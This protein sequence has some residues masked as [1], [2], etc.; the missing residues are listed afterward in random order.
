MFGIKNK[1]KELEKKLDEICDDALEHIRKCSKEPFK[2]EAVNNGENTSV[3]INGGRITLLVNLAGM[4]K[5]ILERLHCE[6]DEF[7]FYKS[8]ISGVETE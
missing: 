1:N 6:E 7:E 4:E 5:A 8:L 2:I 3:K